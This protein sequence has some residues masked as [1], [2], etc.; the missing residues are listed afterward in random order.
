MPKHKY[1][2]HKFNRASLA[3]IEQANQIIAKYE[4][5]GFVLTI[6][7]LY[8]RLVA[9][10][11]IPNRER[12][13]KN[14]ISTMTLA[15]L[16]G[17][18]DWLAF[19]DRTRGVRVF[20]S[21]ESDKEIVAGTVEQ[22]RRDRWASQPYRPEVWVEKQA[23]EGVV[24]S[25]CSEVGVPYFVCRGHNSI[26]EMWQGAQRLRRYV[27]GRQKPVVFYLGDH[28]PTGMH[29][30]QNLADR[31]DLFAALDKT[32]RRI[33]LNMSQIR[34]LNPPP[35]PAK[36][37]DSR[38]RKYHEKFGNDVYELDALEPEYMRDLILGE[39]GKIRDEDAWQREGA[40]EQEQRGRLAK[41]SGNYDKAQKYVSRLKK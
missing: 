3:L 18:V 28:D 32:V 36:E 40:I 24:A 2:H 35:Q 23:L 15:R 14:L 12:S 8:Y 31:L 11:V 26:S 19:E 25:I 7:Q 22:F 20:P 6:R 38:Y 29:I 34:A 9:A 30:P 1:E 21:W 41:L 4:E 5:Q 17:L 13:Y 10:N 37:T 39:I 16:A 27:Q 33:A